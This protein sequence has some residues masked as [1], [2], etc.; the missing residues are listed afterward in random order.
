MTTLQLRNSINRSH[1]RR[2]FVLVPLLLACVALS[3]S[4]SAEATATKWTQIGTGARPGP[5]LPG[6]PNI[7]GRIVQAAWRYDNVQG[8]NILWMGT[9]LGGLWKSIYSNGSISKWI[10]LTD[11]FPGPHGMGSFIVNRT[12]SNKILIGPGGFSGG[13]VNGDGKVYRTNDQGGIWHGHPLPLSK[14]EKAPIHVNRIVEDRSDPTGNTVLAC[15][16]HGIYRS[17]DFGS[18]TSW[19]RVYP[20]PATLFNLAEVTDIVQDTGNPKIWYA[21]ELTGSTPLGNAPILRSTDGGINWSPY[22]LPGSSQITGSVGRISLAAC[23]ANPNVLYA[24][25]AK[26]KGSTTNGDLNGVYRSLN[27]GKDWTGIFTDNKRINPL[28]QALH[29]CA[30]ACDPTNPGHLVVGMENPPL[31]ASNATNLVTALIDW[32]EFDGGHGDFNFFLFRRGM[33][34]IVIANDGGYY[35]YTRTPFVEILDGSGNLLGIEANWLDATQ[36]ALAS[37]RSEPSILLGGVVDNGVVQADA[38]AN[39]QTRIA[40]GDGGQV[41]ISPS[42][43][44]VMTGKAVRVVRL[45]GFLVRHYPWA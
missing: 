16:S 7:C 21:G 22:A 15:T 4:A 2:D 43:A 6:K 23:E 13:L 41:C 24:L 28:S 3:P 38:S 40:D 27:R 11:N 33:S 8:R 12:D 17:E 18:V 14:G 45:R 25:V 36:G 35:I 31:E 20:V 34:N 44:S 19:A 30:I 42:R 29:T 5:N 37:S 32:R 9:A 39:T 1:W 26:E 10:P